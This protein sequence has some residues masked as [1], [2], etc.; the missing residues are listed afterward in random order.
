MNIPGILKINEKGKRPD[1]MSRWMETYTFFNG[2]PVSNWMPFMKA[3]KITVD[4]NDELTPVNE[5]DGIETACMIKIDKQTHS[6]T[7]GILDDVIMGGNS[8][9]KSEVLVD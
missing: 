4:R 1:K 9:S 2:N 5:D 7:W 8:M 3:R 6:T